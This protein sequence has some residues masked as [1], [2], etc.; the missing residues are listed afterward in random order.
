MKPKIFLSHNKKDKEFIK[1]MAD[2][3]RPARID[4]WYD[5]WEIPPGA[6]LR[7][8]IFEEGI[9]GCDM[10]FV[11]LTEH[12]INSNW[13]KQ[14]LDAAFVTELQDKGGFLALYVNK[15]EIRDQLPL[16]LRSRRI[17]AINEENLSE[18]LLE[19]VALAWETFS[20]KQVYRV[21]NENRIEKLELEK[22]VLEKNLEIEKIKSK[23]TN[24][25][26][27]IIKKLSEKIYETRDKEKISLLQ[28][29]SNFRRDLLRG[30]MPETI[31]NRTLGYI[32]CSTGHSGTSSIFDNLML[33]SVIKFD[34]VKYYM[35]DLG[36]N[37]I[38]EMEKQE[39]TSKK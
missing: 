6:S 13:V 10:F 21:L 33:Y 4:V 20:K 7:T 18:S 3:L 28:L 37:L 14:E 22:Q 31:H 35:T 23:E 5:D 29:F 32:D 39:G 36:K 38:L 9:P 17:P 2:A 12:S 26:S 8:K 24:D 16:D 27:T 25:Y 19:L 11:Y 1:Q 30:C 15:D 34:N